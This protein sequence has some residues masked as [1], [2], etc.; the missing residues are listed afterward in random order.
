MPPG[1]GSQGVAPVVY[2]WFI[3]GL[4]LG[5]V[6][7]GVSGASDLGATVLPRWHRKCSMLIQMASEEPATLASGSAVKRGGTRMGGEPHY[8]YFG[9]VVISVANLVVILLLIVVFAAA[10]AL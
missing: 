10:V 4:D 5:S 2:R 6:C 7:R 8:L 1:Q 9:F 3:R